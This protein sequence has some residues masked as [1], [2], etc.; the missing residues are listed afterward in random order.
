VIAW[1]FVLL[2]VVHATG[3]KGLPSLDVATSSPLSTLTATDE[4]EYGKDDVSET[5]NTDSSD[6]S[7]DQALVLIVFAKVESTIHIAGRGVGVGVIGV[8]VVIRRGVV[9]VV[10]RG[11]VVVVSRGAVVVGRGAVV[12]GGGV[13]IVGG[14][15]V[16]V[17]GGTVVVGGGTVVV[18][19]RIGGVGSGPG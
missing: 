15:T 4:G 2:T 1:Q 3:S 19:R 5:H 7:D 12:V 14:G 9:V 11:V 17:G 6:K 16:I 13:V 10:S 8:C 18:V